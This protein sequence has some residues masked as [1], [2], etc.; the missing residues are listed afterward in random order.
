M[1]KVMNIKKGQRVYLAPYSSMTKSLKK[2]L[3]EHYEYEFLGYLDGTKTGDNIYRIDT[4]DVE[5]CDTI[6]IAS[7]NYAS[8]ISKEYRR[9]N[10]PRKKIKFI[11]F[12]TEFKETSLIKESL[13]NTK[14]QFSLKIQRFLF[15]HLKKY[16]EDKNFILFFAPDF[17]DLNIK[18]LYAYFDTNSSYKIAIISDNKTQIKKLRNANFNI[19]PIDSIRGIYYALRSRVKILDHNPIM[20]KHFI[21][22]LNSKSVQ[23]WHGIPLKKIGHLADYKK[24]TY[25]LVVSTSNF[26]SEYAFANLFNYKKLINSGYPRNDI[27]FTSKPSPKSLALLDD[28]IYNF[29]QQTEKKIFVYMPTWRPDIEVPNP[30]E[31]SRLNEFAK[32][33]AIIVVIKTHPFTRQ[34]SFYDASLDTTAFSYHENYK[35]GI[36]FYPT[37]D[38]IYPVLSL[39]HALITD[40]SSVYFDYLLLDKPILFFLYDKEHYIKSH[41]DFMLDF[42]EYTP[43]EKLYTLDMLE[44]AMLQSLKED[45]HKKR[46]ESLKDKLFEVSDGRSAEILLSD[47]KRLQK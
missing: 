42:E 2:F 10:I 5:E 20:Q 3:D 18:E 27:F 4:I 17:V 14:S 34:E 24:L 23:I 40:Y 47:I 15:T 1:N 6:Y 9:K 28:K 41:G 45:R 19:A 16:L 32:E 35:E 25:D 12:K 7:P 30:I 31:L 21:F 37:T 22:L 29:L 36:L 33:N 13:K 44:E 39:S 38:D 8:E 46:R 11:A 43:G 26:V